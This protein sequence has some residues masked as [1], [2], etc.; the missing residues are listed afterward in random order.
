MSPSHSNLSHPLRTA[1]W[2]G[3]S[4]LE[5]PHPASLQFQGQGGSTELLPTSWQQSSAW[6]RFLS[7][8]KAEW[9]GCWHCQGFPEQQSQLPEK[10]KVQFYSSQTLW[11]LKAG[12]VVVVPP[13][14]ASLG[15]G[16]ISHH[17]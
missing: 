16:W 5:D 17:L 1:G 14:T 10:V 9:A 13:G 3:R 11:F 2:A 6:R 12:E 7:S 8:C 4:V 15:S